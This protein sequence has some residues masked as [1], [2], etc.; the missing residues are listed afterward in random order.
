[1]TLVTGWSMFACN[2]CIKLAHLNV[3]TRLH[4][5][6]QPPSLPP[7][8]AYSAWLDHN[9]RGRFLLFYIAIRWRFSTL[10]VGKMRR[11]RATLK[12][13]FLPSSTV[14]CPSCSRP[15]SPFLAL[16]RISAR[17]LCFSLIVVIPRCDCD[18]IV[19]SPLSPV[20]IFSILFFW[21]GWV[22]SLQ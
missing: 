14:R 11:R 12:H 10:L 4:L 16:R 5:Q 13:R 9:S 3:R 21:G 6:V 1:M 15:Q 7:I 19:I 17:H 22:S 2:E 18:L 8:M 20:P